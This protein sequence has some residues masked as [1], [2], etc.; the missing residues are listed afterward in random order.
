MLRIKIPFG[1]MNPSRC[2]VLADLAEEYSDSIC[3][4]TT[5]QDIQLHL[6]SY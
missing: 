3:H 6:H 2:D 4:V 1:G 5:R